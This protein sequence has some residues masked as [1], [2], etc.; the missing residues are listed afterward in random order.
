MSSVYSNGLI[1]SIKAFECHRTCDLCEVLSYF[2]PSASLIQETFRKHAS[3]K[4][5]SNILTSSEARKHSLTY[6]CPSSNSPSLTSTRG[7]LD[8]SLE[9]NCGDPFS[10]SEDSSPFTPN[11]SN[12]KIDFDASSLGKCLLAT[13]SD[14]EVSRSAKFWRVTT[15]LWVQR[16]YFWHWASYRLFC[17]WRC[18][19]NFF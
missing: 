12:I 5:N 19:C 16:D 17:S 4:S 6:S 15:L 7:E 3:R 10:L 9:S 18:R 14:L 11:M 13:T 2:H 1:L 8:S